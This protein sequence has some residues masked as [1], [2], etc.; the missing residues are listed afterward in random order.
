MQLSE[1]HYASNS[2]SRHSVRQPVDHRVSLSEEADDEE[3]APGYESDAD[4]G[5]VSDQA[6]PMASPISNAVSEDTMWERQDQ[7][8]YSGHEPQK[9]YHLQHRHHHPYQPPIP[10]QPSMAGAVDL[11]AAQPGASSLHPYVSVTL[12]FAIHLNEL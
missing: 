1:M 6:T 10:P 7:K 4:S 3:T 11:S 5:I 2:H 8:R 9:S 12:C